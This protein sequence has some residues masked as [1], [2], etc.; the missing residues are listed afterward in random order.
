ML[1]TKSISQ[2]RAPA[3]KRKPDKTSL[4]ET[5]Q[6][7]IRTEIQF[8]ASASAIDFCMGSWI[9]FSHMPV[10]GTGSAVLMQHSPTCLLGLRF[11]LEF[12]LLL[13]EHAE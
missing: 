2:P 11:R 9:P 1:V 8:D 6:C 4:Y 5:H 10:H 12:R 7:L 13:E 3:P